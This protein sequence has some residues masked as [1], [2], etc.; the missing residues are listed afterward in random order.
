[1]GQQDD[2]PDEWNTVHR[3]RAEERFRMVV[4]A[5]PAAMVM[6]NRE[7][8]IVLV[9]ERTESWFGYPRSELLG[10]QV[11]IL[12]PKRYRERHPDFRNQF[13]LKPQVRPMGVG[14]DLYALRKDGSEFP[15]DISLHPIEMDEGLHVMAN[16][17]DITERLRVQEEERRRQAMERLA[18]LG[19]LAGGVAHEI[20][21][22]LGVI[23]NSMY[24]LKLVGE[25]FDE[26]VRECIEEIER[27]VDT[28]NRIVGELLDYTRDRK[29]DAERLQLSEIIERA[30]K[31]TTIPHDVD[32]A[33]VGAELSVDV[34]VDTGQ[35]ERV[36]NNLFQNAI[37]AMPDGGNLTVHLTLVEEFA[38]VE[39]IDTG[40]GIAADALSKVF[41]PLFTTKAKGIGLGLAI[42]RRYVERNDGELSVASVVGEGTTFRLRLPV[43]R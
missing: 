14:H 21:N 36:L 15:V 29:L 19:Q 40:I 13:L 4:E 18:A 43:A 6:M 3:K 42:S 12:I 2:S 32:F 34:E 7:G 37:Q 41:E 10:Q 33:F 5:S 25:Q 24:Y 23:R 11:E 8:V 30:I 28:A 38:V 1:M 20:R 16:I 35:M 27:E 17:I 22:P 39:V 26:E 9:N 31:Q